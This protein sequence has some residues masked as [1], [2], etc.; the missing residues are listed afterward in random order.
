MCNNINTEKVDSAASCGAKTARQVQTHCGTAFNCGRCKSSIN[1]RL[2]LLR[3]Q[4]QSLL[5]TE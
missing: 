4:P 3:G 1:E 5:V 2:T